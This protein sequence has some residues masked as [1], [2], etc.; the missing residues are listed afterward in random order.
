MSARKAINVV[1]F[2]TFNNSWF[3]KGAPEKQ[4]N[5]EKIYIYIDYICNMCVSYIEYTC[6][7][8]KIYIYRI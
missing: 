2:K 5:Q 1:S 4:Q 7:I 8:Y 6:I 3:S